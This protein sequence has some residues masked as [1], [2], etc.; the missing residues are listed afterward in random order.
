M[1][2]TAA[3]GSRPFTKSFAASSSSIDPRNDPAL[4]LQIIDQ[5]P[6]SVSVRGPDNR[7][8]FAN[9]FLADSMGRQPED[10]SGKKFVDMFDAPVA[11]T[12]D[13]LTAKVLQTSEAIREQE[14][15]GVDGT[16]RTFKSQYSPFASDTGETVGV[17]SLSEEVT[18]LRRAEEALL[19]SEELID[20]AVS[21]M[22][23]ALLIT[24]DKTIV[25]ANKTASKRLRRSSEDLVGLTTAKLVYDPA[26]FEK[27][28]ADID[29]HGAL[30]GREI[31]LVRGD[32]SIFWANVNGKT[33][34]YKG[35][36]ANLLTLLDISKTKEAE[37]ELRRYTE[38]LE[39]SNA[40][41]EEFAYV[42]SHD[43]QEPLRKVQAF[44]DRL[45]SRYGDSL[46]DRGLDYL[47]RMRSSAARM[48]V[49]IDDLLTFSRVSS[50]TT[51]FVSVDLNEI[52]KSVLAD[53]EIQ[54]KET[55]AEFEIDEMPTIEG[56]ESRLRQLFQ[57]MVGNALKYRKEGVPPL[58]RISATEALENGE[59]KA[60]ACLISVVDNG[61]G[62]EQEY[63]DRIFRIFQRLHGRD[64]YK[65]TGIGL[66]ICR[67]IV[68]H[69]GG[70][71]SAVSQEGQGAT[72]SVVLP[73]RRL[74]HDHGLG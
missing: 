6:M 39:R 10:F 30:L 51:E 40:E 11:D 12:I 74:G 28:S 1:N 63:A 53:L 67:K 3:Q 71:I 18:A 62:F 41:L 32:G 59:G 35:Q 45:E 26:E 4:L 58:I 52:M 15:S 55:D 65:G 47:S 46:G 5:L 29:K 64:R 50:R 73:L 36:T 56:D 31:R 44:G 61:I 38:E 72:F 25:F 57:N 17:L 48:Q 33:I 34:D 23:I 2:K 16:G 68:D 60:P 66:A 24:V 37:A 14:F 42:A 70:K 9:K 21:V 13:G 69:H 8:R 49:L 54:I 19:Q 27:S 20:A 22:P 7:F 43:L